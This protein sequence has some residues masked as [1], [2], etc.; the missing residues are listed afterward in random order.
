MA[1]LYSSLFD[2]L[3]QLP[4]YLLLTLYKIEVEKNGA[5]LSSSRQGIHFFKIS[6]PLT[7]RIFE[8]IPTQLIWPDI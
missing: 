2:D 3:K 7:D 1:Y 4:I 8:V 6:H 5:M